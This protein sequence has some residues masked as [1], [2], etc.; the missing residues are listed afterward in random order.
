VLATN[1]ARSRDDL[2][3]FEIGRVWGAVPGAIDERTRVGLLL[4]GRGRETALR[5][6]SCD[7][8][9]MKGLVEVYV[10]QLWGSRIRLEDA[11]PSPLEPGRSAAIFAGDELVGY[12][13]QV[14]EPL[15]SAFDLPGE[16]PV[17]VAEMELGERGDARREAVFREPPRFPAVHRDLAFVVDRGTRHEQLASALSESGGE[18]LT[19]SR[20]FDV[21]EGPPLAS[22]EKSLAFML[23]FRSPERSLTNEEVDERV[24]LIVQ[25][26]ADVVGARIR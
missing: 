14:G 5:A 22:H 20:L 26:V 25:H 13:G 7:F 17:L 3:L 1:R 23:V 8:F 4:A 16:L 19:E 2:A 15:R 9:D 24:A 18:L 6:K 11:A 10:E 21:Y 12:L